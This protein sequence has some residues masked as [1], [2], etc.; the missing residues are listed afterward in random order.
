VLEAQV[1]GV[2]EVLAV[3][4]TELDEAAVVRTDDLEDALQNAVL[5]TL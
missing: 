4:R 1:R 2:R 5:T 3:P